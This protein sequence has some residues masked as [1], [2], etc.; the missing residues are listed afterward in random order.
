ME[1]IWLGLWPDAHTTR[2]VAM[3]GAAETVL[4]ARLPLRPS[5]PRA[6]TALL[7]AIALWEGLPVRAVLVADESSVRSSATTLF[8]DTFEVFGERTALYEL[9]WTSPA[10]GRRRRR[11]PLGGMGNFADLERLVLQS[12]AR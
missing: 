9:S 7:E 1:S 3:R 6:V 10:A 8:R 4:K 2:V 12:V 5:S 11:E